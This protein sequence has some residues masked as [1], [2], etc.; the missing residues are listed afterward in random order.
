METPGKPTVRQP[1]SQMEPGIFSNFPSPALGAQG[2]GADPGVPPSC[3]STCPSSQDLK[4]KPGTR[5]TPVDEYR[6]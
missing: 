4:G 2:G 3:P 6:S 1:P 5:L